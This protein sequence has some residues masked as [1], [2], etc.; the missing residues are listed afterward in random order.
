MQFS[1]LTRLLSLDVEGLPPLDTLNNWVQ[2]CSFFSMIELLGFLS[3]ESYF[4]PTEGRLFDKFGPEVAHIDYDCNLLS[5][6]NR[7]CIVYA[8]GLLHHALSVLDRRYQCEHPYERQGVREGIY[9][10]ILASH[11]R[12]AATLLQSPD[13]TTGRWSKDVLDKF[14]EQVYST[15]RAVEGLREPYDNEFMTD[16]ESVIGGLPQRVF[17]VEDTQTSGMPLVPCLVILLINHPRMSTPFGADDT[18]RKDRRYRLFRIPSTVH[19][20]SSV[21]FYIA[22]FLF[23]LFF[24]V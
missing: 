14:R 23:L 11:L 13:L 8:R 12:H 5:P 1:P 21:L 24:R 16:F 10:P 15:L 2:L 22:R 18:G 3:S 9:L 6:S 17:R 20:I 4:P 7:R 19:L